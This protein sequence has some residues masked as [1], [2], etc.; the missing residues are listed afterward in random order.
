MGNKRVY[1]VTEK[2]IKH[3]KGRFG[4]IPKCR[5]CGVEFEIG[6]IVEVKNRRKQNNT[7]YHRRRS[8]FSY[9]Y[10]HKVCLDVGSVPI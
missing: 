8:K 3:W 10:Y 5:L 6:D 4:R 1:E 7:L 2:T 9:P